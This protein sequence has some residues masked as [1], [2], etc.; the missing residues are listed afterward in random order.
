MVSEKTKE[1]RINHEEQ[2]QEQKRRWRDANLDHARK[3]SREWGKEN[4]DRRRETCR[5]WSEQN[6]EH[7]REY[8]QKWRDLNREHYS[9]YQRNYK[10]E[11]PHVILSAANRRRARL[12]KFVDITKQEWRDLMIKYGWKCFYCDNVLTNKTRTIDHL[13][14]L[15]KGGRHHI[16]NLMPCCRVCNTGKHAI[17]YP[18]WRGIKALDKDKL[19][20]FVSR[21]VAEIQ[22]HG[23]Q[24][25]DDIC[26]DQLFKE[27][28]RLFKTKVD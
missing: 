24:V 25:P 23:L 5:A 3:K 18:V 16:M 28:G 11:N 13:I 1:Y 10:I 21:I 27:M 2:I 9:D 6:Q 20:H 12:D 26:P 17:L 22:A 7:L 14:P 19:A 8:D 4:K 15:S